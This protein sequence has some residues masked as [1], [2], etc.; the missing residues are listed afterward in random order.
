MSSLNSTTQY[1]YTA[2]ITSADAAAGGIVLAELY[3]ADSAAAPVRF[4]GISALAFAGT[5]ANAL[6][7]G[8]TIVGPAPKRLLLR[9]VGPGLGAFGVRDRLAQP[10]L[11]VFP[12]GLTQAVAGE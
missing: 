2:R 1:N 6:V 7:P 5:G 8:F 9:A 3:D 11:A 12:S 4:T 10:R